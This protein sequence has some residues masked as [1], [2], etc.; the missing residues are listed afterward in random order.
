MS[1]RLH[2]NLQPASDGVPHRGRDVRGT[3]GADHHLRTVP[4][5]GVEPGDLLLV[6]WIRREPQPSVY[7]VRKGGGGDRRR[8]GHGRLLL[9]SWVAESSYAG[10]R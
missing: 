5:G 4:D 2:R 8:D 1:G 9:N 10:V 6:A 3:G 7:G